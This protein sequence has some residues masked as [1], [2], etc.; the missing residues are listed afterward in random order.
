MNDR[1]KQWDFRYK[2]CF[3][4]MPDVS[5]WPDIEMKMP[6]NRDLAPEWAF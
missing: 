6:V 2:F 1:N 5:L 3:E 4:T